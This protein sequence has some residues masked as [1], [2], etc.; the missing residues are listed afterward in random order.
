METTTEEQL[1]ENLKKS[2]DSFKEQLE[3]DVNESLDHIQKIIKIAAMVAGGAFISYSVYN[4]IFTPKRQKDDERE[5]KYG[6]SKIAR[7]IFRPIL[8]AGVEVAAAFLLSIAKQ[9]LQEYIRDLEKTKTT[10]NG[11][12]SGDY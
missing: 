2:A 8:K 9:K 5:K 10:V 6:I 7:G 1:K 12:S 3:M 4:T 11:D